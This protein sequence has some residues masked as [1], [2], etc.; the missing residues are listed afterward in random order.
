MASLSKHPNSRYYTA[1]FTDRNGKQRKRST[2]LTDKRKARK[3]AIEVEEVERKAREDEMTTV[4]LQKILSEVAASVTGEGIETPTVEEYLKDWLE[5]VSSR[6]SKSTYV[7]YE[8]SVRSFLEDL[9]QRRSMK[10]TS[11]TP[12][13]IADFIS[14]LR[15]S[16]F[17]PGTVIGHVKALGT[18]FRRADK[19]GLILKDPVSAA[20]GELP[21]HTSSEREVFTH[22]EVQDLVNAAPDI[23]WQ[24]IILL[25]YFA[26]ARLGDCV[27]MKWEN[28]HPTDGV[29]IYEQRKTKKKVTVPMHYNVIEHLNKLAESS[30][31]DEYLCPK[32]VKKGPGGQ[33]GLSEGFKR[34][35]RRAVIDL[36]ETK[37]KGIRKFNRRTFHSLRHSFSSVLANAGVSEE[38]RMKLTGHTT[39][40]S[41]A[42]YTHHEVEGLKAA[43]ATIPLMTESED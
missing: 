20:L 34:I 2:K 32:L 30:G 12:K 24:T 1:C 8:K 9:G 15:G 7:H 17:A 13:H 36:K 4:Q 11:V 42:T 25:S 35:A 26:G 40:S 5:S 21:K 18:A 23:E 39:R 43:V 6:N 27:Q 3:F 31:A 14:T 29:I 10:L 22:Q 19:F 33:H 16:G 38:L 37:G 41:H 28:I